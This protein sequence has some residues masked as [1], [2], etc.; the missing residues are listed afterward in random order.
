MKMKSKIWNS[1]RRKWG[2]KYVIVCKQYNTFPTT[3][4]NLSKIG[5]RRT[6]INESTKYCT[7]ESALKAMYELESSDVDNISIM[8]VNCICNVYMT[9]HKTNRSVPN[10]AEKLVTHV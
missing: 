1:R 9:K 7:L 3:Y 5:V 10:I 4:F 8:K 2:E 6:N